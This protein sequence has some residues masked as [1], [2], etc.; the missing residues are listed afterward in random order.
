MPLLTD[1][2]LDSALNY[3][4]NNA[5]GLY[6][7]SQAPATRTE[8]IT[9][10]ALANIAIDSSDFTGPAD[11]DSSGRKLTLATQTGGTVTGSGTGD[12]YAIVSATELLAWGEI[13]NQTLTSGNTFSTTSAIVITIPDP[14]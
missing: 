10:Y 9:T 8:A 2:V 7:C 12:K 6:I 5:N 14:A 11:G 13:T 1:P 3:I 4:K